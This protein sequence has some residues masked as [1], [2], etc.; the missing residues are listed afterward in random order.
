ML[1]AANVTVQ[2]IPGSCSVRSGWVYQTA[3]P[4]VSEELR[5]Q[6]RTD[7]GTKIGR[8]VR[9]QLDA[10][11]LAALKLLSWALLSI[12]RADWIASLKR[13]LEQIDEKIALTFTRTLL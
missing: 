4:R 11:L 7:I 9:W 13:K 2:S 12:V 1:P 10:L 6:L 5:S 3:V 8:A